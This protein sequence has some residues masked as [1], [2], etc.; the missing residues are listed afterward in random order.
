M[1]DTPEGIVDASGQDK[2]N[3]D[4]NKTQTLSNT[5]GFTAPAQYLRKWQILIIKP[6]YTKDANGNYTV[7]DKQHDHALDVSHL[8]CVFK[9]QQTTGTAVTI[10]TLVVYNMNASTE[11]DV[12]REGFQVIIQAGYQTGQY[13]E[14]I[15][16]DIVQVIRN[17]ENGIDYRLEILF[18]K[19]TLNFDTNYVR[20]TI[21]AG[22]TPRDIITQI[23]KTATNP[24]EINKINSSIPNTPL[25]RGKV[26][27]GTVGKYYRDIAVMH[28][29]AYYM[30]DNNQLLFYKN[31]DEIPQSKELVLTPATGL[32]G[33]PSYSDN[34]IQISMLMDARVKLGT[35]IKIDN[36]IIQEQLIS[37]N[38][39]T[40]MGQNQL[41]Q[42]TQFDE[43]GEYQVFSVQHEGDTYGNEWYTKVVGISRH[44][45]T[46]LLVPMTSIQSTT[47]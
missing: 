5:S 25:P 30:D 38:A 15:T 41:S 47:R 13:G 2:N 27:Y 22:A 37:I 28:D 34:G 10:G 11:G 14:I 39:T 24:I 46:G 8:R 16:G 9:T 43:D 36:S 4:S 45:R 44:G 40:G 6:A 21:A 18:L 33:T 3:I 12:I 32:V 35:M 31:S 17:R 20:A 29:A 1:A 23:A 7:R 26:I 42:K 19:G